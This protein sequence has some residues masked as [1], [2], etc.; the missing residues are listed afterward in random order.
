[1]F[2]YT[3]VP[4]T[5]TIQLARAEAL[6]LQG[7]DQAPTHPN[8]VPR[9]PSPLLLGIL[10]LD[11]AIRASAIQAS[12]ILDLAI[13]APVMERVAVVKRL[14]NLRKQIKEHVRTENKNMQ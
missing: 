1:V 12:V 2:P 8:L 6:A 11:S 3:L 14:K 13:L 5:V 10:D 9:V 4:H 7:L